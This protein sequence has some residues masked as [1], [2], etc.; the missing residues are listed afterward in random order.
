MFGIKYALWYCSD[1]GWAQRKNFILF[2]ASVGGEVIEARRHTRTGFAETPLHHIDGRNHTD[3]R[4]ELDRRLF[5]LYVRHVRTAPE[6]PVAKV[7]AR[8]EEARAARAKAQRVAKERTRTRKDRIRR[9]ARLFGRPP[10]L[11]CERHLRFLPREAR[12]D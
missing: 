5:R 6:T 3:P 11:I 10:E 4:A 12:H 8:I 9:A 1:T 7:Q 2:R